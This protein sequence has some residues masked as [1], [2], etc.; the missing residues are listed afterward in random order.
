MMKILL[1]LAIFYFYTLNLLRNLIKNDNIIEIPQAIYDRMCNKSC[2]TRI[3]GTKDGNTNYSWID[4][5]IRKS[6][7]DGKYYFFCSDNN[8]LN[9]FIGSYLLSWYVLKDI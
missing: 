4:T 8:T 5:G 6:F 3:S 1:L 7:S 2:Q 9:A